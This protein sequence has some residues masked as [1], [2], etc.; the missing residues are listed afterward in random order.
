MWS[1]EELFGLERKTVVD[2]VDPVEAF[3]ILSARRRANIIRVL[4][5]D[6]PMTLTVATERV[7]RMEYG[8]DIIPAHHENPH[9]KRMY[10][11]LYQSHLD[12]MDEMG[13]ID[14]EKDDNWLSPNETTYA[15]N[16]ILVESDERL[17]SGKSA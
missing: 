9:Y 7:G 4:A 13:V 3:N 5:Q 16:E 12:K 8:D 2:T 10:V 11:S 1:I 6:G 15:L 14:Y 17:A